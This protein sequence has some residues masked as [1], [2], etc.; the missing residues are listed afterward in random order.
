MRSL[1]R[2][3]RKRLQEDG[4]ESQK[5]G[6]MWLEILNHLSEKQDQVVDLPPE[7]PEKLRVEA[8]VGLLHKYRVPD[9][10]I[11]NDQLRQRIDGLA[12]AIEEMTGEQE[13]D[14]G[15][16]AAKFVFGLRTLHNQI[17]SKPGEGVAG[18]EVDAS[19]EL[20]I[21]DEAPTPDEPEDEASDAS[22]TPPPPEK[23]DLAAALGVASRH[24]SVIRRNALR[25]TLQ[26]EYSTIGPQNNT[27][28]D[29]LKPG[30]TVY[31][32]VDGKMVPYQVVKDENGNVSVV[33]PERPDKIE[34]LTRKDLA[35]D[36][37]EPG[38]ENHEQAK[39]QRPS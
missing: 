11:S 15:Q 2:H 12:S 18:D 35:T 3:P 32:M 19:S 36:L 10:A 6:Q 14:L 25:R 26:E 21:E 29:A 7:S 33:N 20:G 16:Y 23:D 9:G 1:G 30:Q 4:A 22:S 24:E 39:D 34:K 31:R 28:N 13:T 5:Y 37:P 38:D 17:V 8:L 27:S